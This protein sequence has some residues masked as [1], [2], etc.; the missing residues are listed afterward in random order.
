MRI[1]EATLY[2]RPTWGDPQPVRFNG[3]E[4]SREFVAETASKARYRFYRQLKESLSEVRFQDIRVRSLC[5]RPKQ[6]MQDGWGER[7]K[8]ANAIIRVIGSYGRHFLSENSDRSPQSLVKEPFFAYF[9]VDARNELWY[10]DRYSRKLILVRH[11]DWPGFSDGGT[12]RSLVSLLAHYIE[13]GQDNVMRMLGPWPEWI[14][15][16]DLWAYGD[17]MQ[18]VRDEINALLG[19]DSRNWKTQAARA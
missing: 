3:R 16:G 11:Q 18:K 5:R 4:V 19:D 13:N 14:C 17:D 7:L 1:Y 8:T 2:D 10:V 12:L 15:G 9:G 6:E